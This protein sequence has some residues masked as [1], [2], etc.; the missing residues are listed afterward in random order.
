MEKNPPRTCDP[1]KHRA[2]LTSSVRL[3]PD[4]SQLLCEPPG[5]AGGK[6][7]AEGYVEVVD[8]DGRGDIPPGWCVSVMW[9][10]RSAGPGYML[11]CPL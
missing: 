11:K 4:Q 3:F 8:A 10:I 7:K 1:Q 9:G 6:A 5:L 2:P